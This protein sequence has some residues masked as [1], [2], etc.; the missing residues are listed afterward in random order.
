MK[1][2]LPGTPLD[3]SSVILCN[4]WITID[5]PRNYISLILV[6]LNFNY[7][8]SQIVKF[9]QVWTISQYLIKSANTK[10]WNILIKR[11]LDN[12]IHL[13]FLQIKFCFYCL[14]FGWMVEYSTL[15]RHG[16]VVWDCYTKIEKKH[17]L[18]VLE[19]CVN[20]CQLRCYIN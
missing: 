18:Y 15:W 8:H 6:G 19:L 9:S 12:V 11:H 20:L 16:H 7:R 4:V 17:K 1:E 5:I 10:P 2:Q 13:Q 14:Q 3:I